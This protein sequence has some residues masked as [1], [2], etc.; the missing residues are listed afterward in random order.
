MASS[1]EEVCSAAGIAGW[2][3]K[4]CPCSSCIGALM[5]ERREGRPL[6]RAVEA[7]REMRGAVGGNVSSSSG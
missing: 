2:E 7:R 1:V 5:D 6:P 3:T 4:E